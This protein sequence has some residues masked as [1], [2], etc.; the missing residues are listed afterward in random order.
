MD[1][2]YSPTVAT[3]SSTRA[4][5]ASRPPALASLSPTE[6]VMHLV[7]RYQPKQHRSSWAGARDFVKDV[8][9]TTALADDR[10]PARLMSIAAPFVMW[11]IEEHGLDLRA[12]LIF[13]PTLI[14]RYCTTKFTKD[15]TGGTYRSVLLAISAAVLP[16]SGAKLTAMHK[17]T[18]LAP[19]TTAEMKAHTFWAP[20]QTTALARHRAM[21]LLAFCAGAGLQPGEL[22]TL[23][24]GDVSIDD[25]GVVVRVTGR[26]SRMVPMLRAWEEPATLAVNAYPETELL[27]G[28]PHPGGGKNMVSQFASRTMG[29]AP[30]PARLRATWITTHLALG[31]PIK[32][33]IRAGGMARFENLDQYLAFVEPAP[34]AEHRAMLRGGDL[35]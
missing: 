19:Y 5:K 21:V 2:S 17:R 18:I 10:D 8:V 23:N 1:T 6:V 33:L 9:A 16:G 26:N 28:G 11:C 3:P 12:E 29:I 24:R 34:M 31:T 14:N 30:T 25:D 4:R 13:S 20:G 7:D 22:R 35:R 15:G 32:E 27:W